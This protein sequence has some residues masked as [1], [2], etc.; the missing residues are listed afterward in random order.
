MA[1]RPIENYG[2]IGNMHTAA[3]VAMDGSIDWLCLPHFDSPSVF[4]ALLD[5][6]KG[7]RFQIAA[8]AGNVTHKQLY[9]P[10]TNV[11]ITRF[12]CP[13]GVGQLIDIM[14]VGDVAARHGLQQVFRHLEVVRGSIK[15]R[16][17]CQPSTMPAT[18]KRS[19]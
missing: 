4:A 6:E 8:Q 10:D 13:D 18:A 16:L 7:G 3:L 12:L 1:Y 2:S 9:W 11:L 14:P 5:D 17:V 19:P 15:F